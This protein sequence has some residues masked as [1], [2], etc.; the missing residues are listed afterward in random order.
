MLTDFPPV[1]QDKLMRRKRLRSSLS[2]IAEALSG[3]TD[4]DGSILP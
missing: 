4:D 2:P 3:T 1:A